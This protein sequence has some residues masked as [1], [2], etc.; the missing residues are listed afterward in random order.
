MRNN[1][2]NAY[3]LDRS[4]YQEGGGGGVKVGGEW[5]WVG[6]NNFDLVLKLSASTFQDLF[7]DRTQPC[8]LSQPRY[9]KGTKLLFP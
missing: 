9:L 7:D 2:K 8:L 1:R 6:A 3:C 4:A 5:G